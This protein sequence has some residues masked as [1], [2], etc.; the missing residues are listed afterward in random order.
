MSIVLIGLIISCSKSPVSE[1]HDAFEQSLKTWQNLKDDNGEDYAYSSV[2][3]SAFG[4]GSETI[5]TVISGEV[6]RRSYQE[7][8][9]GEN[10]FDRINTDVS[11]LEEGMAIGTNERGL[12]AVTIDELYDTCAGEYLTVNEV[13]NNV[14]FETETNGVVNLCGFF[15]KN[16]ADDC[17]TGF[18]IDSFEFL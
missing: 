14:F 2:S 7:F 3:S 17:F 1:Q 13:D 11:Y 4:F 15:P 10:S 18:S 6:V 16:C 8:T 12:M 9:F 5:I